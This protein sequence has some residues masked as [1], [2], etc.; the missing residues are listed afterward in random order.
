MMN[1]PKIKFMKNHAE[2]H[3]TDFANTLRSSNTGTAWRCL[4]TALDP[5]ITTDP[6]KKNIAE[7]FLRTSFEKAFDVEV[8]W[9]SSGHL[10][11]F[12]QGPVRA[13]IKEYESFLSSLSDD[14]DRADYHFF[15]EISE[16]WGY[17]DEVLASVTKNK[18]KKPPAPSEQPEEEKPPQSDFIISADLQRQ[19]NTRYK[20]LLLIVED[21]RVTRHFIQS[22][23]EKYC[24]IAIAWDAE[25]AQ[26]LY[27]ALLPNITF[28]DIEL[29]DGDGR[30]LAELFCTHD[31]SSFIVMVSGSLSPDNV[32]RCLRAGVKGTVAKP[33]KEAPLLKFIDR[34]NK[35]KN[36]RQTTI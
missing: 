29:P 26:K 31:H 36:Q 28:L 33:I 3:L 22:I 25:Q 12:F 20:P 17:F 18:T 7:E 13:V 19:R 10:F 4:Y 11:I 2:T 6:L 32:E 8:F 35:E 9:L 21:D 5:T 30:N 24:D 23:M 14:N 27:Q 16:F 1:D 15:W 34:H